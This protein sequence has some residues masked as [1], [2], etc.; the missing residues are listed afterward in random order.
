LISCGATSTYFRDHSTTPEV[1]MISKVSN[2]FANLSRKRQC[3][4]V[5]R[6]GGLVFCTSY[7]IERRMGEETLVEGR[8]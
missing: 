3:E 2:I 5:N 8:G 1:V 6:S 7:D 4:I